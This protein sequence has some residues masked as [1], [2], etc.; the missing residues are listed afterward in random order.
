M[1]KI[2]KGGK[3]LILASEATNMLYMRSPTDVHL[4]A[5]LIGVQ[6]QE[7]CQ[8]TVQQNCA[9]VLQHAH[10]RKTFKGVAELVEISSCSSDGDGE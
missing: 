3:N 4:L 2:T 1:T 9:R 8:A 5:K 10:H 6:G 7:G